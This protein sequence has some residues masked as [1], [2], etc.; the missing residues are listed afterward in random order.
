[1]LF[2]VIENFKDGCA[3]AVFRRFVEKGRLLPEKVE[4]IDSWV[5]ESF[6]QCFQ[7][8]SA[9]S[10]ENLSAWIEQWSDLVE[11]E[12]IPV[13]SSRKAVAKVLDESDEDV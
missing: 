7:L 4:Y 5:T 9:D 6:E 11:F 10:E 8:M 12:I 3:E 13:I 1:M 2:M